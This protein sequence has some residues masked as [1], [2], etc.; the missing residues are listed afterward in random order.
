MTTDNDSTD[1]TPRRRGLLLKLG[2]GALKITVAALILIGAAAAYQHQMKTSPR[3]RRQTPARQAKLVQVIS[4]EEGNCTTT[5]KAMG[6]VVPAQQVTLHPQVA[7]QIVEISGAIIPG[8]IIDAGE[9]IMAIDRRDYEIAV[10]Q[11]RA[12]VANAIKNL[13]VEQGNQAVAR[14]EY[15]LLGEIVTEEDQELVLREPQLASAQ[16]ALESA[17]A[18][19][20]KA[21]LDLARCDITAPFNAI[22]RE[23]HVDLGATVSSGSQLVT[24]VA[25]DEAWVELKVPVDQLKWLTIPQS[26]DD[27]GSTVIVYNTLAWGPDRSRTGHVIRLYGELEPAGKL[28]RLLA[29]VDDPFCLKDENRGQPKLLMGSMIQAEIQGVSL[30]S[31]FP[32]KWAHLRDNNKAV[33]IMDADNQLEVRPVEIAFRGPEEVFISNGLT[34]NERLVVTDIAAPVPGMPL[35][36]ADTPDGDAPQRGQAQVAYDGGTRQ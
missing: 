8:G 31:V 21:Q 22:V 14:Q 26:N 33:W 36:L 24:L 4:V 32:V 2:G 23:K 16:S 5:V 11:R 3:A 13:K 20:R 19:L 15:E 7:G 34:A 29:A 1:T 27:V 18:A 12:D 25:T 35:R 10:E 30:A 17:Q 6:P 28:A 9:K